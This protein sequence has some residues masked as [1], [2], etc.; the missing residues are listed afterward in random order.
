[1]NLLFK[2]LIKKKN[3]RKTEKWEFRDFMQ[4]L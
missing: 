4:K 1:M 2:K 3:K